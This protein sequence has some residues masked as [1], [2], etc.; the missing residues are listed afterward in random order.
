MKYDLITKNMRWFALI[1]LLV[2]VPCVISLL[3]F[4]LRPSIDF[5][6]GTILE[7]SVSKDKQSELTQ[8]KLRSALGKDIEL[9]SIQQP[10]ETHLQ[11]RLSPISA[12]QKDEIL[13]KIHTVDKSATETRFETLGPLLGRELL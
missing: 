10:D 6:G 4:G 5:T 3:R 9:V 1:S 7:L 11:L 12:K 13:T 8:N 2:L